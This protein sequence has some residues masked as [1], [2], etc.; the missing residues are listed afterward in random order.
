MNHYLVPVDYSPISINALNYALEM[1]S[2]HDKID[3]IHIIPVGIGITQAPVLISTPEKID[4]E[5]QK[6]TKYIDAQT[7]AFAW[8]I[9]C[10]II[11]AYGDIVGQINAYTKNQKYKAIIAGTRDKYDI[12]DKLFGTISLGMV[13]TSTT[14]TY[15]IPPG[16]NYK[17]FEN[18]LLAADNHLK[19]DDYL[20]KLKLWNKPYRSVF[21]IIHVKDPN[22]D[23]FAK[24]TEN[25]IKNFFEKE[26][27]NFNYEIVNVEG[28]NI[29][30]TLMGFVAQKSADI[31]ILTPHK[32]DFITS[33]FIKSLSKELILE[34][35]IPLLFLK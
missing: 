28:D 24:A 1:C 19:D 6:L 25:V 10:E 29:T 9:R 21:H 27:V 17:V 5:K 18:T 14:T 26:E 34:S 23:S 15:L 32:Q 13:K 30:K 4:I 7:D 8:H 31:I 33:L 22:G 16:A 11:I 2:E 20:Q 35:K 3:I 12:V